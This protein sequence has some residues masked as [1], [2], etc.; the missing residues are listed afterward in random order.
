VL[1]VARAHVFAR[2]GDPPLQGAPREDPRHFFARA[3]HLRLAALHALRLHSTV[4]R[5]EPLLVR[6][7]P[8]TD[9]FVLSGLRDHGTPAALPALRRPLVEY[10]PRDAQDPPGAEYEMA[11]RAIRG[12]EERAAR[13]DPT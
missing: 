7:L 5:E 13:A 12:I 6:A 1:E 10:A 11:L 9:E 8:F 4:A 2:A 3:A